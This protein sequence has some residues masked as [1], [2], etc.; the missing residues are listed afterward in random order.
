MYDLF[1]LVIPFLN[2]ALFSIRMSTNC[3]FY[4]FMVYISFARVLWEN[5]NVAKA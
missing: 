1:L 3:I 2:P 4:D 5:L